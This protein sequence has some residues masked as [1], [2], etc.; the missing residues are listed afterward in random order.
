MV[1]LLFHSFVFFLSL[2]ITLENLLDPIKTKHFRKQLLLKVAEKTTE[3]QEV[4][5]WITG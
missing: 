4:T 1:M 5:G 2:I 3:N